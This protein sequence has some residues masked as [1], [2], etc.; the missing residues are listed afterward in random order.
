MAEDDIET[1][2]LEDFKIQKGIENDK[3]D[4]RLKIYI[5]Q[6]IQEVE[7]YIGEFILPEILTGIITQMAQAKFTKAGA[8][9]TTA[10]SEEGLSY[11][12]SAN[13]L[14][15]FLPSLDGYMKNKRGVKDIGRVVT[16]D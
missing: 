15:P 12:F 4:N 7:L 10:T 16:F 8:E 13:D 9:G 3:L 6:A 11:T 14:T 5:H 1:R 2:I